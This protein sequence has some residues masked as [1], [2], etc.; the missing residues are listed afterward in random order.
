[1]SALMVAGLAA[2]S[3]NPAKPYSNILYLMSD[4]HDGRTVDPTDG[5]VFPACANG[6]PNPAWQPGGAPHAQPR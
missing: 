5:S 2:Y 6:A 3:K 4:S 1:M